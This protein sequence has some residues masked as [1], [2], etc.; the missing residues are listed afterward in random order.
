MGGSR[1]VARFLRV[2]VI[3]LL[4]VGMV[5]A[6]VGCSSAAGSSPPASDGALL[7]G[8]SSSTA[9]ELCKLV[10]TVEQRHELTDID[11]MQTAY[12]ELAQ[13]AGAGRDMKS[14]A[15]LARQANTLAGTLG[16][17][18]PD[19]ASAS[20]KMAAALR[21]EIATD[22]LKLACIAAGAMGYP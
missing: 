8:V 16:S 2:R 21:L 20:D 14:F 4:V 6:T 12:A 18:T 1:K 9:G 10:Q 22:E 11:G 17:L 7:S 3:G 19:S 15:A 13:R 5:A